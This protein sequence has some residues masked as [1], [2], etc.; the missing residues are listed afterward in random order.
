MAKYLD[1]AGLTYL[2]GK[3]KQNFAAE[4]HN[5]DS[6]YLKDLSVKIGDESTITLTPTNKTLTVPFAS[7]GVDGVV[8]TTSTVTTLGSD[9]AYHP[10]PIIEGVP[11]YHD[12]VYTHPTFGALTPSEQ[13]PDTLAF[14][15]EFTVV[16]GV[17]RD[18]EGH[19]TGYNTTKYTL[20]SETAEDANSVKTTG[21][22]TDKQIV[23][24]AGG[25]NVVASGI[26]IGGTSL[27]ADTTGKVVATET[28]VNNGIKTVDSK[29]TG[30]DLGYADG[31]I[32]LKDN[33]GVKMNT[34]ISAAPFIKDGMLEDA[35]LH[36]KSGSTWTP[37]L[38]TGV[39]A[40]ADL[41]NGTY[42]VFVWNTDAKTDGEVKSDFL[43]VGD[44]IDTYEAGNGINI[45]GKTISVKVDNTTGNVQLTA[46]TAGLSASVDL[47]GK[48]DKV[49]GT[50]NNIVLFDAQGAIKDST[51]SLNDY[52]AK[53]EVVL[54]E[55]DT[56]SWGSSVTLA[57]VGGKTIT[58]KLPEPPASWAL[59]NAEIDAAIAAA[60]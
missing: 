56:L 3:I 48:V 28:A 33:N 59:T 58:A 43:S 47:S 12:T 51:K 5:H 18:A 24:G 55:S 20:P 53:D 6:V 16:T 17:T 39:T 7:N 21:D 22:L 19:I 40:P 15:G 57:T 2:W 25:K 50:A 44:L 29:V 30:L 38:P 11:Y 35:G 26:T 9:S 60:Q 13:T 8:T 14:G 31:Y 4:G 54:P 46:G 45:S 41:A 37:A 32:Y 36:T 34:G 49:N 42:I 27:S 1:Q 23:L 52:V 10:V